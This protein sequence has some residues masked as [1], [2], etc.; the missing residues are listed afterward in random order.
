[1]AKQPRLLAG[2]VVAI[3]G[4]ARGIG[5]ATARAIASKGAKVAIGDLDVELAQK[6]ASSLGGESLGLEL[7]VTLR[8]SF[9]SFISQ[10][11]ERLGPID[12]LI[13][14]AGIM[15]LGAFAEEDDATARRMIERGVRFVQVYHNNWD[16]HG[17]VADYG[18]FERA[19]GDV[20]PADPGGEGSRGFTVFAFTDA[21]FEGTEGYTFQVRSCGTAGD[22]LS[23]ALEAS[24]AF[25][26]DTPGAN[27]DGSLI[28]TLGTAAEGGRQ[29]RLGRH[30]QHREDAADREV[31]VDVGRAVQR[32][33][34]QQ[35]IAVL[36]LGRRDRRIHL[37]GGERGGVPAPFDRAQEDVVG[38]HVEALLPL[39]L[40]VGGARLAEHAGERAAAD[41]GRDRLAGERDR[42]Q[43]A[44]QLAGGAG[45]AAPLLDEE[46][47]ERLALGVHASSQRAL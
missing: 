24:V 27:A 12:V 18:D 37:L 14:N 17:N 11:E 47:G 7:D 42:E 38:G 25:P 1:M 35:V 30:P 5:E 29:V 2:K 45:E 20:S 46:L 8:D 16:T 41:Q 28:A 23:G 9:A 34:D 32:V 43:Q 39:A 36:A 10:V 44:V 26:T 31:H 13:N 15:P 6:T 33:E 40:R 3:T 19:S 4:G 22:P 21:L